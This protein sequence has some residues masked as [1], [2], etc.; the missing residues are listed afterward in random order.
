MN[1]TGNTGYISA[2]TVPLEP[3]P[4]CGPG[5]VYLNPPNPTHRLGSINC[6][7]CLLTL[8]AEIK[9][10]REL[11]EVWNTRPNGWQP[12][13]TAP[14]SGEERYSVLLWIA[15]GG[16]GAKGAVSFGSC[17][18]R[19]DGSVQCLAAGYYGDGWDI[20]HWMPLPNPPLPIVRFA[21]ADGVR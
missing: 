12:I 4:L 11:I 13:E 20:T 7:A 15:N 17:Y 8:P 18:K 9:D 6:P 14:D 19:P 16:K 3:C 21:N 10:Q 2:E 5:K 1:E